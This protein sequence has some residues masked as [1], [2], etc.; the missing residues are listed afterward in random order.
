MKI[1]SDK[2]GLFLQR[3]AQQLIGIVDFAKQP[4]R[5]Q[6]FLLD[7]TTSARTIIFYTDSHFLHYMQLFVFRNS[8][9]GLIVH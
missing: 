7:I 2:D 1:F 5:A 4:L 3:W 9:F 8:A 6:T